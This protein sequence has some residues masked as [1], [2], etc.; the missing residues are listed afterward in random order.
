M[1]AARVHGDLGERVDPAPEPLALPRVARQSHRRGCAFVK[2]VE[3]AYAVRMAAQDGGRYIVELGLGETR[4][5]AMAKRRNERDRNAAALRALPDV[6]LQH[7][8]RPDLQKHI[9]PRLAHEVLDAGTKLHRRADISP[10]IVHV[11]L[12][13]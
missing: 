3:F 4:Y 13:A 2:R 1:I 9:D 7:R 10:P 8:L 12:T 5:P 6:I 11:H